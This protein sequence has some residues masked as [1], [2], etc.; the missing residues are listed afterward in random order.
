M[1][2]CVV[3][4]DDQTLGEGW[5]ERHGEA[6]AEVNALRQIAPH[7]DL[8]RA[9][10]YVTL[11]PCSHHGKTPPCADLLIDQGIGTV[12]VGAQD[13][14][15]MVAGRGVARLREAGIECAWA[16][17]NKKPKAFMPSLPTPC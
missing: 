14:N 3:V 16:R 4:K 2:G 17:L 5:H 15:P 1:V 10:A 7:V 13:P 9:T 6:H 11:E 12:V 8:G